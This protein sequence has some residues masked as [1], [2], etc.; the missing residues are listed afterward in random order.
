MNNI[1]VGLKKFLTNKNTVTVLGVILAILVLY[2]GYNW[3]VKQATNPISVPYALQEINPSTQITE[4]M[5]GEAQVPPSMI[6][7]DIYRSKQSVIDKYSGADC[8]IPSGSLFYTRCVVEKDQ[9]PD[10]IILDYPKGYVLIKYQ[11]INVDIAKS[12]GRIIKNRLPKGLRKKF[13][14]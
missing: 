3:R 14:L 8:L 7:G 13:V 10:S 5:V 4:D 1:T 9:L 12:D 2:I 11:G 6:K